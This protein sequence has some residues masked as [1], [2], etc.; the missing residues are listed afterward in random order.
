MQPWKLAIGDLLRH[1]NFLTRSTV[2]SL[3]LV[4]SFTAAYGGDVTPPWPSGGSG[5]EEAGFPYLLAIIASVAILGFVAWTR[6]KRK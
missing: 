5:D 4:S 1:L 2:Y 6:I 3:I